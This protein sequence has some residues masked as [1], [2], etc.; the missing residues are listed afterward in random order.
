MKILKTLV[1]CK[2][3]RCMNITLEAELG[4]FC[5]VFDWAC[6]SVGNPSCDVFCFGVLAPKFE[7]A[8]RCACTNS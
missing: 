5:F 4:T 8:I 3:V 1:V 2:V 6:V 7:M